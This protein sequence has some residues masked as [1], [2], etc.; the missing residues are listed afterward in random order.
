[1]VE[2]P[3]R[4]QLARRGL[5]ARGEAEHAVEQRPF[6]LHLDVVGDEVARGENVAAAAP[7]AGHEIARRRGADLERQ[8]PRRA[9][10]LLGRARDAVEV[11]ETARELRRAVHDSDLRLLH[12][13]FGQAQRAPLRAPPGPDRAAALEVAAEIALHAAASSMTVVRRISR[14]NFVSSNGVPRCM[15]CWLSHTSRSPTR[16]L[17]RQTNRGWVANSIS[18]RSKARP[19]SSGT[20]TTSEA[21]DARYST[22]R[23]EPGCLC[24][25]RWRA[26]GRVALS[27]SLTSV[28]PASAREYQIECSTTRFSIRCFRVSGR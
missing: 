22:L 21:C 9:D 26:G 10:R 11:R 2:A 1:D 12:V 17:C 8:A 5:V 18:P 24:T 23:P 15:V 19:S 7:G 28:M 3:G 14:G 20:P 6:H 4:H 25:R 13:R 27:S 16:H